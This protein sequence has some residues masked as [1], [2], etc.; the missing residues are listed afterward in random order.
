MEN[1]DTYSRKNDNFLAVAQLLQKLS[2]L[3]A[4]KMDRNSFFNV[5]SKELYLILHHD[6]LCINLYD[7]EKEFLNIFTIADGILIEDF[8][9]TR[10][11]HN[12]V[13]NMAISSRKPVLIG[14]LL[15]QK[16]NSIPL[17]L[18][19]AGLTATIALPLIINHKI[20]GT[21]HVS[22]KQEPDNLFELMSFLEKICPVLTLF[23]YSILYDEKINKS[24]LDKWV[25][26]GTKKGA[27]GPIQIEERLLET[28]EM[29][30]VMTLARNVA[31][32]NIPVL[33]TGET[34]TGKSMLAQWLHKNS[35]RRQANFVKVNCPSLAPTLFES[36][37]FGHAKG[38]FTGSIS[39]RIGRIEMAQGGTL[40]L[41]EITE[42]QPEMQSKLLQVI[43]EG[44]FERV[45]ESTPIG[46]DF[47][48][49][50]ASNMEMSKVLA[51]GVLRQDLF[52]R[53]AA[54]ILHMPP[55][56]ERKMDLPVFIDYFSRQ[57]AE[58]YEI[59]P[60]RLPRSILQILYEYEWPGNIR[61]L[62]N[63]LSRLL[64]HSLDGAITESFVRESLHEW[65]VAPTPMPETSVPP[66]EKCM[67]AAQDSPPMTLE[68][69][70]R[71]HIK[72]I[73]KLTN[74]RLSGPRGASTLLG[75]PRSTLQHRIRKL[76]IKI[77]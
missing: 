52:Y 60:V 45:G 70:E 5:M 16:D 69:N 53:L 25:D 50:S 21:L 17:Q 47:Q 36:E 14:N 28:R 27:E 2:P 12:T 75:V 4:T 34:G 15:Q 6:R 32:I 55:L 51:T 64:L 8:S 42:L 18:T 67:D 30:K 73:L 72:K 39:K 71:A 3:V 62:R 20:I 40:F 33:I 76:N 22:F 56:R 35:P 38:A 41:D 43:E 29:R 68:E 1:N 49:I 59:R 19:S 48:I 54:V 66:R 23:I 44:V 58:Q 10:I 9:N 65:S 74:G 57:F 7:D 24:H 26:K 31:K 37:L 13:A 77:E 61:E 46:V 63:V 11:V